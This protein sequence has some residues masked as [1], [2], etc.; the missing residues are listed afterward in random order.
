MKFSA[1]I[2]PKVM[3]LAFVFLAWSPT[4]AHALTIKEE[5]NHFQA[6]PPM[7]TWIAISIDQG[8]RGSGLTWAALDNL[9]QSGAVA[10]NMQSNQ[11][12]NYITYA[13]VADMQAAH[14]AWNANINSSNQDQIGVISF[15]SSE[16][17]GNTRDGAQFTYDNNG[18]S[19]FQ[20]DFGFQ[21][22]VTFDEFLSGHMRFQQQPWNDFLVGVQVDTNTIPEPSTYALLALGALACGHTGRKRR[23]RLQKAS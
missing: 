14:D 3:G 18:L 21:P 12:L 23:K 19:Q 5:S 4:I 15:H 22:G 17:T 6:G 13:T 8:D 20:G 10:N 11:T 2:A 9:L 16:S 7:T 1:L